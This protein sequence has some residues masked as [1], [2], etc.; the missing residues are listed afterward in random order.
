MLSVGKALLRS[1]VNSAMFLIRNRLLLIEMTKQELVDQFAGQ[2]LGNFWVFIHPI[3]LM[4]V[5]LVIFGFVFKVKIGATY[6]L[7][8]DYTTYILSGLIPWLTLQQNL[9]KTCNALTSNANLVKQVV[10]PIEV[11]PAK[12]VFSTTLSQIL[13]VS[14]LLM[15]VLFK[16]HSIPISY[17]WLPILILIQLLFTIGIGFILSS[18]SVFMKDIREF[19]TLFST[20]G[21]FLAPVSYLPSWVPPLFKPL[22]YFNPFSYLIWCYQDV[23][24]FGRLEH[25]FAWVIT[26]AM[27]LF[28]FA[29]GGNI[30][31]K[32]KPAFGDLL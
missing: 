12:V 9:S 3:F 7:P 16:Y 17:L 25:P 32:L 14:V 22:L 18:L 1:S 19:V 26:I 8:L 23:L 20:A 11:L 29:V 10:F 6:D 24:Y 27:T 30:F 2:A 15:Y 28:T 13:S 21:I 31:A 5:Y 4:G